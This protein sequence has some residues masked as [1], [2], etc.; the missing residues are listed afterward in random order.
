MVDYDSSWYIS[1]VTVRLKLAFAVSQILVNA[2][3]TW[4]RMSLCLAAVVYEGKRWGRRGGEWELCGGDSTVVEKD[5]LIDQAYEVVQDN[6]DNF[7]E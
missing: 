3:S 1:F 6:N 5:D 2:M 7:K 4:V